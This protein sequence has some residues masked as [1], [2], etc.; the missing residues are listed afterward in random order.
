MGTVDCVLQNK[1]N[2]SPLVSAKVKKA[3]KELQYTPNGMTKILSSVSRRKFGFLLPDQPGF[4][5]DEVMRGIEKVREEY[6]DQDIEIWVAKCDG[7]RSTS[8]VEAI[9]RMVADGASGFA[10][11]AQ[12]SKYLIKEI[13]WLH[14]EGIPVIT[15]NSDIPDSR[16]RCF[17]GEDA[18]KSG[19]IAA[20]IILKYQKSPKGI[21]II[22]GN[23]EFFAHQSRVHGFMSVVKERNISKSRCKI[24]HTYEDEQLICTRV[25]EILQTFPNIQS[26]Y[27]AVRCTAGYQK[28]I[29]ELGLSQNL[30]V[31]SHDVDEDTLALMRAGLIDFTIDQDMF[32]QGYL[33][34][35]MLIEY[36]LYGKLIEH[37]D[38]KITHHIISAACVD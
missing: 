23:P 33:P 2:I 26:V 5:Y 10:I 17:I 1:G 12:N 20:E 14:G 19:K 38:N 22:A 21:L 27:M 29:E 13:S 8:F 4:F 16:R 30:F 15:V 25:K 32:S 24:I 31:V 28:A 7:R 9:D 11:C 3:V 34:M 6:H 35:R 36:A 18:D 37:S